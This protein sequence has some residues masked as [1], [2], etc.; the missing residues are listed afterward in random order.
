[1][2]SLLGLVRMLPLPSRPLRYRSGP[3]ICVLVTTGSVSTVIVRGGS[4]GL[5]FA[6]V[7]F[8]NERLARFDVTFDV[9][10]DRARASSAG[11]FI[12]DFCSADEGTF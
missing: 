8:V 11:L 5:G 9:L 3:R 2:V 10:V 1:M 12:V 7:K 4:G 6:V